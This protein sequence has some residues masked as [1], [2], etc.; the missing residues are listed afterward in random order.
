VT[1]LAV[2][3]VHVEIEPGEHRMSYQR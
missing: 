3:R 1:V 2:A